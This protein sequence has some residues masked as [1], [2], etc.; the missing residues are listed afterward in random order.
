MNNPSHK[1]LSLVSL[2]TL[3]ALAAGCT[4]H[5]RTGVHRPRRAPARVGPGPVA[6]TPTPA[7][8]APNQGA[9]LLGVR[10]VNFVGDKDTIGVTNSRGRFRRI[11]LHV[12]GSPLE[13][14][15]VRVTFGDGSHFSPKTRLSFAQG[16]WTRTI[17]L[18]G[19]AR[20]IRKVEFW[21]R[22][23]GRRSGKAR[24]QL[25]GS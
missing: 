4:V 5:T 9:V 2:A 3:L 10:Q 17:D 24:V 19:N 13:M 20:V 7:A 22:S 25:F 21:Y 12:S 18:P 14:Y 15:N 11:K 16:G 1:L 6:A 8:P 23:V